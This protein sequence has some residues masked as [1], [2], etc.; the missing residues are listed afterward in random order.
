[1]SRSTMNA[2][3]SRE[4]VDVDE[5]LA[6]APQD[7]RVERPVRAWTSFGIAFGVLAASIVML[8]LPLKPE[9]IGLAACAMMLALIFVKIPIAFAMLIPSL[10]GM[11]ALRGELLVQSSIETLPYQQVASWT[12]SVIPMFVLMGLVLWRA[13]LTES[14]YTA[15]RQWLGWLPGGLAVGT[16]L[17]GAGVAAVSGSSVGTT[18]ALSRIGIPEMLKAGYDKRL[19]LGSVIVA[20]LP[21]QLIPPSI[22]MVLYAGVAEVQVGPQLM[23]GIVPGILVAVLFSLM[24]VVFAKKWAVA[25]DRQAELR[26]TVTWR[27]RF[28][29]LATVWPIPLLIA[30]IVF[31]MYSGVFTA[32]EAGAVAAVFSVFILLIWCR[33]GGAWRALAGASVGTVSSVGAIF[34]AL[35]GVEALSRMLALTGLTTGFAEMVDSMGMN[36]LEF[37]FFMMVVYL[38]LGT[39]ME[40]L[41]MMLLTVPILMPTLIDLDISLLWYGVF[42]VFM[43]EIAVVSPPVGIL[44]FIVYQITKEREVNQ[45]QKIT[46]R[47]VFTASFWFLPMAIL[48]AV[49]LIL[50]PQLATW[51]PDSLRS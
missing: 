20:G 34:L 14:I 27:E 30:I 36:R 2:D 42:A 19:A 18:Y 6:Q 33:K 29:S 49:L 16:N 47:D 10:L 25:D 31:G 3:S 15:A 51:L 45:G 23:A 40:P 41:P 46:L 39:F 38:I 28:T 7:E 44:A 32:T 50:F 37:L 48:V 11:Y 24:I 22:L 35:I 1:M 8:F 13:G 21:G 26:P 12:L 43:G 17:A 5:F 9:A 4:V